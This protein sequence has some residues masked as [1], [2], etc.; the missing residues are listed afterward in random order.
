MTF[1]VACFCLARF[2]R[3]CFGDAE[4]P[5]KKVETSVYLHYGCSEYSAQSQAE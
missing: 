1:C 4:I 2:C 5:P 3:F